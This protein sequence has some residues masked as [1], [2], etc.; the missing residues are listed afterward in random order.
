MVP[1]NLLVLA[2]GAAE[3]GFVSLGVVQ[4]FVAGA[5]EGEFG[6]QM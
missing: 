6:V 5:A 4:T 3:G 2:D 1:Q